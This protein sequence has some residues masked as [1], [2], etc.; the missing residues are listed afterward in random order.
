MDNDNQDSL[1]YWAEEIGGG[2]TF[3]VLD[4]ANNQIAARYGVTGIPSYTLISRNMEYVIADGYATESD[5]ETAL[6][7]AVPDVDWN[8]PPTL[9]PGDSA[10]PGDGEDEDE[11]ST[12]TEGDTLAVEPGPFGGGA[13]P[14]DAA[15]VA[16]PYGGCSA[17]IADE[18]LAPSLGWLALLLGAGLVGRRRRRT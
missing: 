2:L 5:I 17:S 13:A 3:P 7:E 16:S 14:A 11:D 18:A 4:D 6:E 12:E 15:G 10:E 8:E 9:N 1:V